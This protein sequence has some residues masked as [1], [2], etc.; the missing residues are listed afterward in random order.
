MD[1]SQFQRQLI[2]A[3]IADVLRNVDAYIGVRH[4]RHRQSTKHFQAG[5][6]DVTAI[7]VLAHVGNLF[8]HVRHG[9]TFSGTHAMVAMWT[10]N[11][12]DSHVRGLLTSC[13]DAFVGFQT[14]YDS[15]VEEP[16]ER[17]LFIGGVMSELN[18]FVRRQAHVAGLAN[19]AVR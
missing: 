4:C 15:G 3:G 13:K 14:E 8:H 16:G 2:G 11:A 5:D 6:K 12:D 9:A 7:R 10:G 18:H 19:C 1:G 17:F